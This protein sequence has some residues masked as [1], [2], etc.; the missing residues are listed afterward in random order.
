MIPEAGANR[1]LTVPLITRTP[2]RNQVAKGKRA[3]GR[4]ALDG[5]QAPDEISPE[6]T[7]SRGSSS[8]KCKKSKCLKLY[9]ECFAGGRVCNGKCKCEDCSNMVEL[10]AARQTA[11][12]KA[13]SKAAKSSGGCTCSESGC[14]KNYCACFRK[15][16]ACTDSCKC[17]GCMNCGGASI[18]VKRRVVLEKN[19]SKPP[20]HK[21][22]KRVKSTP[23]AT[24]APA[25]LFARF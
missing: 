21:K 1:P 25:Q 20:V 5:R 9:C 3:A 2:L 12:G 6:P 23:Q 4:Q 24:Q 7:P 8:C 15:G 17:A 10:D 11:M 22:T 19:E 13:L 14:V 18:G 16:Q